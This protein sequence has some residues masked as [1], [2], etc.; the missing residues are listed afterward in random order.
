MSDQ[1]DDDVQL[2]ADFLFE[3]IFELFKCEAEDGSPEEVAGLILKLNRSLAA[4]DLSFAHEVLGHKGV[5][6]LDKSCRGVEQIEYASPEDALVAGMQSL[7]TVDE[8]EKAKQ[9]QDSSDDESED[10]DDANMQVE[11]EPVKPKKEKPKP[12]VDDDGFTSVP[13]TRRGKG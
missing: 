11:E 1:R 12:E 7:M 5:E 13:V 9:L 8:E 2:L 6:D 3:R 4:G 10:D